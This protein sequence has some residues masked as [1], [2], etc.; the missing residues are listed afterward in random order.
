MSYD[1]PPG[2]GG[3]P[4]QHSA[5]VR[6]NNTSSG[7]PPQHPLSLPSNNKLVSPQ[8]GEKAARGV[9]L[10]SSSDGKPTSPM[11]NSPNESRQRVAPPSQQQQQQNSGL[12]Q[13][14][15]V[16]SSRCMNDN[17]VDDLPGIVSAQTPVLDSESPQTPPRHEAV[18]EF[19]HKAIPE[20]FGMD[21]VKPIQTD[22]HFF[23]QDRRP[24]LLKAATLE[25]DKSLVGKDPERIEQHRAFLI[26][27]NLNCRVLK[28]WE[29]LPRDEREE[30]FKKEEDD[31]QRF[32]EDDEVASRH[33]FTLTARVR[34]PSKTK[35]SSLDDSAEEGTATGSPIKTEA[36]NTSAL[37][38]GEEE[39]AETGSAIK[40]EGTNIEAIEG[41]T[42]GVTATTKIEETGEFYPADVRDDE[43]LGKRLSDNTPAN[44]ESPSKKNKGEDDIV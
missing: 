29:D 5:P 28:E 1:I 40:I 38:Y 8:H 4:S 44:E 19:I 12:L 22:F 33:C 20:E 18:D 36:T 32:M 7:G 13:E 26:N 17:P 14:D 2:Y 42:D 23:V 15:P 30:Y 43:K 34:S 35:N 11:P 21:V 3:Y 41:S 9:G 27:S 25:V 39:G 24:T 37:D 16:D 10:K 6:H 31:R